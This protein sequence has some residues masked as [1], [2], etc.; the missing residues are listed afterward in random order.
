MWPMAHTNPEIASLWEEFHELVNMPSPA[1]RDWLAASEDVI[2]QVAPGVPRETPDGDLT[3]LGWRVVDILG[4]RKSDLTADDA[5]VM[6]EVTEIIQDRLDNAPPN[7]VDDD[8][9]RRELMLLGHDPLTA[10]R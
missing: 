2:S 7:G 3:S 5:S 9:W 8:I 4:R 10:G 6:R 1:L